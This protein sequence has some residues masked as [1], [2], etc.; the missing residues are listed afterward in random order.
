MGSYSFNFG[1]NAFKDAV[2]G[3]GIFCLPVQHFLYL[4]QRFRPTFRSDLCGRD[5]GPSGY[6]EDR[7]Y[8]SFQR[9]ELMIIVRF[10]EHHARDCWA[11][12]KIIILS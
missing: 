7:I 9:R 2:L 10:C 11:D 5:C 1:I 12:G 8:S 6:I 4:T 3:F